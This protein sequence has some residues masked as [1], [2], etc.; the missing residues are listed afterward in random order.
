MNFRD[1]ATTRYRFKLEGLEKE[2][3]EV[4]SRIRSARYTDLRPGQYRFRV[5]ASTDG[6]TWNGQEASIGIAIAPPWWMTPWSRGSALLALAACFPA[7]TNSGSGRSG[8]GMR[9]REAGRPAHR[10]TGAGARPGRAGQP[11]QERVPG[12]HE[13]RTAHAAERD[14][15]ILQPSARAQRFRRTSAGTSTSSIAAANTC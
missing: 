11:G 1:R 9:L 6:R 12:Q 4:D 7:P 8:E 13:P 14:P 5:Q 10:R 15:G 3:T 2:W